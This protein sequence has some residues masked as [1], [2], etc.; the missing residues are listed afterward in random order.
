MILEFFP[1]IEYHADPPTFR[2]VCLIAV[3]EK[4]TVFLVQVVSSS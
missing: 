1:S 2:V 3:F 4:P